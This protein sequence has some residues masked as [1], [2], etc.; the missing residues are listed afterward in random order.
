[1]SLSLKEAASEG[2]LMKTICYKQIWLFLKEC[3]TQEKQIYEF[4]PY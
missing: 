1:M 3:Y 4:D 2:I